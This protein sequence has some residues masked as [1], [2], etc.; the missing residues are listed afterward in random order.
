MY[1]WHR[2]WSVLPW[3]HE[4]VSRP[5]RDTRALSAE[6]VYQLGQFKGGGENGKSVSFHRLTY[7]CTVN[8]YC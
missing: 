3:G 5:V 6:F 8:T 2:A 4:Q 7:I 1:L